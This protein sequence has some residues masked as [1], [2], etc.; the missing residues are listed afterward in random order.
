EELTKLIR[1]DILT[2]YYPPGTT[3]YQEELAKTYNVSRTPVRDALSKLAH[4][5]FLKI[6]K[7]RQFKVL[8]INYDQIIQHYRVREVIDGLGAK[9]LAEGIKKGKDYSITIHKLENILD[10]ME[11]LVDSW[12]IQIWS[13]ENVKFHSLIIQ[14]TENKPLINQL[15]VLHMSAEFFYPAVLVNPDRARV[16]LDEHRLILKAI[17]K[18]EEDLAENI[19]R[20]HIRS[21]VN[22]V[23]MK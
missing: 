4:E 15:P 9:L 21:A 2:G 22:D 7:R 20:F 17:K 3:F 10:K 13:Q 14:A 19:S 1:K 5:G 16:A 6:G 11:L 12:D 8:G 18:G 23:I